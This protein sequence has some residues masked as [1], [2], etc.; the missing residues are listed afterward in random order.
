MDAGQLAEQY[1][2]SGLLF[3]LGIALGAI[4][5]GLVALTVSPFFEQLT[6]ALFDR[7]RAR[8]G[9]DGSR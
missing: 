8:P 9:K 3:L 5:L 2:I 4:T 7:L 6:K 1:D